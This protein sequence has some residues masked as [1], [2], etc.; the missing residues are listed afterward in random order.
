MTLILHYHPLSSYCHKALI[1][2]YETGAPFT[3]KSVNLGDPDERAAFRALW[4]MGKFPVLEDKAGDNLIPESTPIIEWLDQRYPAAGLIPADPD[5]ARKTRL[6]DR[7]IDLYLHNNMQRVVADRL[8]PADAKDPFG[9]AQ[10]RAEMSTAY[11]L[12]ALELGDK[13]WMM[14][15]TFTLADC[16]AAPALDYAAR[17][18]P[19]ADSHPTLAA[20]YRR[21]SERPSYA[22]VLKEA[23]P[24]RHMFPA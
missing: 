17:V 1:A 13:T 15:D 23:E 19:Y 21:L 24:F 2:L 8:R 3:P 9:V 14:G 7:V 5:L 6:R 4:P 20:Y 22:R 16:A 10:Y 18:H 11:D 12:I